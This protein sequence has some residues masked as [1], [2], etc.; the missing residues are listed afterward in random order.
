MNLSPQ[1]AEWYYTRANPGDPITITG[2]PVSG[3]WDDGYTEWFY[4]WKQLLAHS[5]TGMAVQVGPAGSTFVNPSTL[6][7]APKATVLT[8]SKP[9][10]FLAG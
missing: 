4:S 7:S 8:G 6:P 1:H 3:A 2:S 9:H 10:N 5:V